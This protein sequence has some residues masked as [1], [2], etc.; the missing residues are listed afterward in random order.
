MT[1]DVVML[2]QPNQKI[3]SF[4]KRLLHTKVCTDEKP[5]STFSLF[6]QR[7]W[8]PGFV[9]TVKANNKNSSRV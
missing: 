1:L 8:A 4:W 3:I 2:T 6:W 7:F 9:Y 5:V